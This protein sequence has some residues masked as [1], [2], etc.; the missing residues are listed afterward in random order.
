MGRV[1][2]CVPCF[3]LDVYVVLTL[4]YGQS[5]YV[6]L[7][8]FSITLGVC[9]ESRGVIR[10]L[11]RDHFACTSV[12]VPSFS[13]LYSHIGPK[14]VDTRLA[15]TL[16]LMLGTWKPCGRSYTTDICSDKHERDGKRVSFVCPS[17]HFPSV[18]LL[19]ASFSLQVYDDCTS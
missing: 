2:G 19:T 3:Y 8:R 4:T 16:N 10:Y 1:S 14:K 6:Y 12:S 7:L 5:S 15:E 17:L 9:Q 13:S 11:L 18:P